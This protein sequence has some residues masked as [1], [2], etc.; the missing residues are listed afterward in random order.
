MNKNLTAALLAALCLVSCG[1]KADESSEAAETAETT[2]VTTTSAATTTTTTTTAAAAASEEKAETTA[3]KKKSKTKSTVGTVLITTAKTKAGDAPKGKLDTD[4]LIDKYPEIA[5]LR[6]QYLSSITSEAPEPK[7]ITY[8]CTGFSVKVNTSLWQELAVNAEADAMYFA[9]NDGS[10]NFSFSVFDNSSK[11]YSSIK[12]AGEY[13]IQ[14]L[15]MMYDQ[16]LMDEGGYTVFDYGVE[17]SKFAGRDSYMITSLT[18]RD[19]LSFPLQKNVTHLVEK[20]NF[21]YIINYSLPTY[22]TTADQDLDIFIDGFK[23]E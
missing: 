7:V 5:E 20:D 19:G 8:D 18:T 11:R 23:F 10:S 2:T 3:S 4:D 1:S 21:M 12:E 22:M 14:N 15:K 16:Q 9:S 6:E 17:D 13:A